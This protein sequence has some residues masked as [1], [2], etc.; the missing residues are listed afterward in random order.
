MISKVQSSPISIEEAIAKGKKLLSGR[1]SSTALL[2]LEEE[3]RSNVKVMK[4][5][6][7]FRVDAFEFALGDV[8]SNPEIVREVIKK[9]TKMFI[10]NKRYL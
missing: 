9:S 8:T 6:I 10:L 1:I 4:E 7:D 2:Q 3:Y 5:L